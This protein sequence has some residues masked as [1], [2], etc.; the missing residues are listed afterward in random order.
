MYGFEKRKVY[1]VTALLKEEDDEGEPLNWTDPVE[2]RFAD[3]FEEAE[4]IKAKLL[5]G[6]DEFYGDLIEKCWVNPE[7]EEREIL[8]G[9]NRK[10]QSVVSKLDAFKK[11][12][13]E[14]SQTGQRQQEMKVKNVVER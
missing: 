12:A 4:K 10:K 6:Q 13:V 11:K 9:G 5:S 1:V 8:V 3:T 2:E 7:P 14:I